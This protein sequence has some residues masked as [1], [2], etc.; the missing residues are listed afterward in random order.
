MSIRCLLIR[1][2]QGMPSPLPW[3]QVVAVIGF[4]AT[5]PVIVRRC[6]GAVTA[7]RRS[8]SANDRARHSRL[9]SQLFPSGAY[10][11][12]PQAVVTRS[13]HRTPSLSPP[14]PPLS[15]PVVYI[16]SLLLFFKSLKNPN[17]HSIC[18]YKS[19]HARGR[20]LLGT[21]FP[22]PK[23]QGLSAC[24]SGNT[25]IYNTPQVNLPPSPCPITRNPFSVQF[26]N[27]RP[28]G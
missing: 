6:G 4:V 19:A 22:A 12:P 9:T 15:H 23:N 21:E 20:K 18:I 7:T 13:A 27:P 17:P 10:L 5:P 2:L 1:F 25:I 11:D 8:A 26:L 24:G 28:R 3:A 16:S 14:H